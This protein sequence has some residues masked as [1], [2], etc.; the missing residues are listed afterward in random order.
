M[1]HSDL[2]SVKAKTIIHDDVIEA[3]DRG[4]IFNR[5]DM[6]DYLSQYGEI[7][8]EGKDYISVKPEGFK[9]AIRLKGKIYERGFD[10]KEVSREIDIKENGRAAAV[11]GSRGRDLIPFYERFERTIKKRSEYNQSR[12]LRAEARTSQAGKAPVDLSKKD[13]TRSNRRARD[14]KKSNEEIPIPLP[15]L[16]PLTLWSDDRRQRASREVRRREDRGSDDN[17]KRDQVSGSHQRQ[18]LRLPADPEDL[19]ERDRPE[20]GVQGGDRRDRRRDDFY[21]NSKGEVDD[22][23]RGVIEGSDRVAARAEQY[24]TGGTREGEGGQIRIV[25]A[26]H[27]TT[28]FQLNGRVGEL[29]KKLDEL[30]QRVEQ[31][32]NRAE[33]QIVK[34]KQKKRPARAQLRR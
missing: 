10:I 26:A 21:K 13:K 17:Q 33:Q 25:Y 27:Y 3:I 2:S 24:I 12:Y 32:N 23:F 28:R 29:I 15:A 18:P 5:S 34:Q 16:S 30:S 9:K 4:L 31:I 22:S 7:T 1:I 8:R 6:R 19:G 11:S 14:Y 20:R